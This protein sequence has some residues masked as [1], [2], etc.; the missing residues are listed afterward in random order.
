ML[1]NQLPVTSDIMQQIQ[2]AEN[3]S[4]RQRKYLINRIQDPDGTKTSALEAAGITNPD[5]LYVWRSQVPGFRELDESVT[6]RRF[7]LFRELAQSIMVASSPAVAQRVV[8]RALGEA[9]TD[10]QL[11]V[12][13]Q[14][15]TLV[16]KVSQVLSDAP[17]QLTQHNT[18]NIGVMSQQ[19]WQQRGADDWRNR[20][21]QPQRPAPEL[22]AHQEPGTPA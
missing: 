7:H 11:Q 14:A 12:Q 20:R 16:L 17:Q 2:A 13:H 1:Q 22:P 19:S 5:T 21:M 10:R 3:F 8:D 9:T 18:L 4:P 15:Q 6:E